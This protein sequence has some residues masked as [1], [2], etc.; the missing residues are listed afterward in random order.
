MLGRYSDLVGRIFRE[1]VCGGQSRHPRPRR[2]ESLLF[3]KRSEWRGVNE[4]VNG[5]PNDNNI[6]GAHCLT[7]RNFKPVE[8]KR[9]KRGFWLKIDSYIY[10]SLS[11]IAGVVRLD[12]SAPD[13][14]I[15]VAECRR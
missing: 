2:R 15:R 7:L 10:N 13:R 9:A 1:Q 12:S 11:H 4:A 8:N 3:Q 6:I 14:A 5:V